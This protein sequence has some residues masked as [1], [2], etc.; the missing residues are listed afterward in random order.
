MTSTR[1]DAHVVVTEYGVAWLQDATVRQRAQRLIAVA[2]PKFRPMLT[3]GAE[4]A[5]LLR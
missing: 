2:H 5:G 4:R 1:Y 3:E